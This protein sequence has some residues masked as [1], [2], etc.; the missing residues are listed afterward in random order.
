MYQ[1]RNP[2]TPDQNV[3]FTPVEYLTQYLAFA[4]WNRENKLVCP[5]TCHDR[6]HRVLQVFDICCLNSLKRRIDWT[7]LEL[8]G[9]KAGIWREPAGFQNWLSYAWKRLQELEEGQDFPALWLETLKKNDEAINDWIL[10][11]P[12]TQRPGFTLEQFKLACQKYG[13]QPD[14]KM[15]A[16]CFV[17]HENKLRIFWKR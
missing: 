10:N 13:F 1:S 6:D 15:V 12:T 8:S 4:Q 9:C 11:T 17:V 16:F 7:L 5:R 2:F 3:T 14:L